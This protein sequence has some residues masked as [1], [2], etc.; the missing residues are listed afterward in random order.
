MQPGFRSSL[1]NAAVEKMDLPV[2]KLR[3]ARVVRH[4]ANVCALV[5]QIGQQ[6]H[7][8]FAV[9]GIEVARRLIRQKNQ[10][11]AGKSP[12]HRHPLL[13]PAGKLAPVCWSWIG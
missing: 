12:C 4:H 9:F 7:H 10:R 1:C 5:V 2:G 3:V 13:L 8:G 11:V 6:L